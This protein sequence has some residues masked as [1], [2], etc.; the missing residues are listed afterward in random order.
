MIA[1]SMMEIEERSHPMVDTETRTDIARV[2][3]ENGHVVIVMP[4]S[5]EIGT[6]ELVVSR[7][8]ERGAIRLA[9]RSSPTPEALDVLWKSI[10][11]AGVSASDRDEFKREMDEIIEARHR[12]VPPPRDVFGDDE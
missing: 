7:E 10:D 6:D 8:G 12:D 4:D 3:R 1:G 11:D 2:V 5:F 9:P